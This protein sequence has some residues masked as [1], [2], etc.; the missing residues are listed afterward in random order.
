MLCPE[1]ASGQDWGLDTWGPAWIHGVGLAPEHLWVGLDPGTG[2]HYWMV[3][4]GFGCA[5]L[6]LGVGASSAQRRVTACVL[7]TP[8]GPGAM[9]FNKRPG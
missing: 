6:G 1:S 3:G 9:G 4:L 5:A 7:E 8:P 2:D